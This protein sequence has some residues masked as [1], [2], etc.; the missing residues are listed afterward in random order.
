MEVR[1]K[2]RDNAP[3]FKLKN[4][5]EEIISLEDYRG[6]KVFV[7]FYPRA[8]TPGCTTQ[9]CEVR[10]AKQDLIEMGVEVVGISNDTPKKQHNFDV[11][12]GL[13]FPLLCDEDHTVCEQFGVWAEKKMYGKTYMGLVR[14]SFLIDEEGKIMESWY[15][16][17]PKKTVPEVINFL[18]S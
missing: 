10:D 4:Q 5:N 6:K 9:S 3:V 2:T 17:S 15:K 8:N 14:S 16:V 13:N 18:N 12:H 11:K 7:Y 1:L